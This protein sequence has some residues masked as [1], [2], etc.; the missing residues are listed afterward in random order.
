V[1]GD[2]GSSSRRWAP[3]QRFLLSLPIASTEEVARIAGD[4]ALEACAAWLLGAHA[5]V[6]AIKASAGAGSPATFPEGFV[7][8]AEVR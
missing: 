7:L 5:A 1:G 4:E 2:D 8:S 3:S 6:E